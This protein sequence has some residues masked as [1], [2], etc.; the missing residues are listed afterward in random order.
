MRKLVYECKKNGSV[1][2]VG[3]LSQADELKFGGWKVTEIFEE[4]PKVVHAT[5][6]QMAQRIKV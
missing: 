3:T 4:V 1:V 5:P 2:K 6:K